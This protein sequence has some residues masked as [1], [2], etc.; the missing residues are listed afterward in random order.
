[1]VNRTTKNNNGSE[2]SSRDEN[3]KNYEISKPSRI[4]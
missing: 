3:T 4:V 1:M 2:T